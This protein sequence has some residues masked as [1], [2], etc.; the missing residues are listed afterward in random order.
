M[1]RIDSGKLRLLVTRVCQNLQNGTG[2]SAFSPEEE[3]KLSVSLDLNR[4][5]LS[6]LLDTAILIYVQAAYHVVKP[7]VM[8]SHMRETFNIEDEK[9]NILVQTW[10]THAKGIV[11]E[12]RQKSIFPVQV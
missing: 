5:D 1:D 10:T 11:D 4:T 7:S 3:E 9:I 8:E 12:L 6:L 2:G